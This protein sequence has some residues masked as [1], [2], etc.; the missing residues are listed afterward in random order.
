MYELWI[1]TRLHRYLNAT[2]QRRDVKVEMENFELFQKGVALFN[3]GHYFEAHEV[4]EDLWRSL[5]LPE[6]RFLQGL[7]QIAAGFH[8]YNVLHHK[9]GGRSL[10]RK[11]AKNMAPFLSHSPFSPYASFYNNIVSILK[12]L[13]EP[14]P[15]ASV[16]YFP[17]NHPNIPD[18]PF[19]F[20]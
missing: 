10:L 17:L 8:K 7:I 13:P 5:P 20:R 15:G 16:F 18:A 3:A 19:P 2:R 1:P 4:W 12:A 14:S 9:E 11:G 6:R